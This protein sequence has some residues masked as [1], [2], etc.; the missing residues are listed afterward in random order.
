MNNV[1][2]VANV[3]VAALALALTILASGPREEL[4]E[5]PV[6]TLVIPFGNGSA[7]LPTPPPNF[8]GGATRQLGG[9]GGYPAAADGDYLFSLPGVA[10]AP[11]N[12]LGGRMSF[13]A[14]GNGWA[15]TTPGHTYSL[16]LRVHPD[17]AFNGPS[18]PSGW[19]LEVNTN[20][21]VHPVTVNLYASDFPLDAW[22]TWVSPSFVA[23]NE[24]TILLP[25]M[26]SLGPQASAQR[27]LLDQAF[28]VEGIEVQ[29]KW[30]G[31]QGLVDRLKT[32]RGA[33]GGHLVDVQ[34]R[35]YT[36]LKVPE[37]G[38]AIPWPY[39]CVPLIDAETRSLE[40]ERGVD[41]TWD[42]SVYCFVKEPEPSKLDS[43]A[44]EG[45][46][47]LCDSIDKA[48]LEDPTLGGV[49]HNAI[50]VGVEPQAGVLGEY[51]EAVVT[52]RMRQQFDAQDVG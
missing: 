22:Q 12:Q 16:V 8:G 15:D 30:R 24:N 21:G 13:T 31:I 44:A 40:T 25:R 39:I 14:V 11:L 52:I 47:D 4:E 35:V 38:L 26:F 43:A 3:A 9:S 36:S 42:Q 28:L 7:E 6:T 2:R 19:R 5:F 45:L 46:A 41:R 48:I 34:Q 10:G 49:V 29:A 33:A 17:H 23:D 27:W 1:L 51:G 18:G 20:Q 37:D 32:I 50:V